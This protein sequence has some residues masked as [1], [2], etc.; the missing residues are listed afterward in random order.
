M[1]SGTYTF[2]VKSSN[3]NGIWDEYVQTVIVVILPPP[4]ITWWAYTLYIIILVGIAGF[5]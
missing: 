2:Y 5:I 4:W 1:K 3:S